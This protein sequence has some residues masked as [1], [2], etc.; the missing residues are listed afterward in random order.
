[1]CIIFSCILGIVVV[2]EFGNGYLV[3]YCFSNKSDTALYKHYFQCIKN[4]T[5]K[6]TAINVLV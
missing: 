6:I 1:M 3:V 4:V 2:D 5:G